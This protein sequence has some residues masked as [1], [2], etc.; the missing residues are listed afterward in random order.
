MLRATM[1]T[2]TPMISARIPVSIT[3]RASVPRST[4]MASTAV[5]VSTNRLSPPSTTSSDPV[6]ACTSE[7]P[8]AA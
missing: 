3:V 4:M 1:V 2:A 8:S 6:R 7:G 5:R